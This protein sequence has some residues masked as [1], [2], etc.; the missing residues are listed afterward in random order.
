[1]QN[2][3]PKKKQKTKNKKKKQKKERVVRA[4]VTWYVE[5][6][7]G[8][9][10]AAW[11]VQRCCY[12]G[13]TSS[14]VDQKSVSC[15]NLVPETTYPKVSREFLQSLQINALESQTG[16]NFTVSSSSD[17]AAFIFSVYADNISCCFLRKACDFLPIYTASYIRNPLIL[18][19]TRP[20]P[21]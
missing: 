8:P 16:V 13:S 17:P 15:S 12:R 2:L 6:T 7:S 5:S 10:E 11:F 18:K 20:I 14:R 19:L 1:M 9:Q 3:K 4:Y 21:F